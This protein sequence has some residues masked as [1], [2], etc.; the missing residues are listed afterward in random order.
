M[1]EVPTTNSASSSEQ[2]QEADKA[3]NKALENLGEVAASH[4]LKMDAS[5]N[6][7]TPRD[8]ADERAYVA[9]H[10]HSSNETVTGR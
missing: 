4:E 9:A 2:L 1:N 3:H 5:G 6:L 8:Q 7:L 10:G